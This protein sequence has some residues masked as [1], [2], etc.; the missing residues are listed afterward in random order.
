MSTE[1][2]QAFL[3]Q[4]IEDLGIQGISTGLQSALAMRFGQMYEAGL[5]FFGNNQLAA[6]MMSIPGSRDALAEKGINNII[7][8]G[9]ALGLAKANAQIPDPGS[10]PSFTIVSIDSGTIHT[11]MVLDAAGGPYNFTDDAA[12]AGNVVINNFSFDDII[13]FSN[14]DPGDYL[15]ASEGT[16]VMLSYNY[17]DEGIDNTILL[18]GVVS[19]DALVYDQASFVTAIGFDAFAG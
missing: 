5:T 7:E 14:A 6:V 10:D 3:N 17:N 2:G 8:A 15:F 11:P 1:I 18:A 12:V 4:L 9:S 19:S 13:S 16:D